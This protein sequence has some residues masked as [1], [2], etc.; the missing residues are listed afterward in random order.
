MLCNNVNIT[1]NF[2]CANFV[3]VSLI[4]D[5]QLH[6]DFCDRMTSYFYFYFFDLFYDTIVD[7]LIGIATGYGLDNRGSVP[8]RGKRFF[9]I[10][11]RPYQFSNPT[12]L[13][14]NGCQG[15]FPRG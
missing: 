2:K 11:Q 13:L 8:G 5:Q 7:L 3:F 12:S 6:H 10:P 15:L 9:C 1:V 14:P 4:S